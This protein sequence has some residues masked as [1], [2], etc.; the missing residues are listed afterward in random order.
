MSEVPTHVSV[1]YEG[2][3]VLVPVIP[4]LAHGGKAWV[5]LDSWMR[6]NERRRWLWDTDDFITMIGAAIPLFK[7]VRVARSAYSNNAWAPTVRKSFEASD[8]FVRSDAMDELELA[9]AARA[10]LLAHAD[11]E[12]D[13]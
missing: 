10:R 9:S 6:A 2:S 11:E 13:Q 1:S 7:V 8:L 4:N 3:I 5:K 12:D